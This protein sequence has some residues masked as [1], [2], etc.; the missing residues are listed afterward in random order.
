M[1]FHEYYIHLFWFIRYLI[2]RD[3]Y[4]TKTYTYVM[5]Y[6]NPNMNT[7]NKQRVHTIYNAIVGKDFE[8]EDDYQ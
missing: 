2:I 6:Y 1:L 8:L 3:C 7:Y 5:P 4:Y